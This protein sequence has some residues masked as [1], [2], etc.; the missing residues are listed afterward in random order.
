[1]N[2]M[3]KHITLFVTAF[4]AGHIV[5]RRFGTLNK[6]GNVIGKI[7]WV[8]DGAEDAWDYYVEGQ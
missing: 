2:M 3:T 4:V 5:E 8:G 7:P 6:I 1:M